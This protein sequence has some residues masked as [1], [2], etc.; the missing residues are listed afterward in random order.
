[1]NALFSFKCIVKKSFFNRGKFNSQFG[2]ISKNFLQNNSV[3]N[4]NNAKHFC[5]SGEKIQSQNTNTEGI[6][7]AK[8]F[9]KYSRKPKK[10]QKIWNKNASHKN[11]DIQRQIQY[12]KNPVNFDEQ[13]NIDYRRF[14][15]RNNINPAFTRIHDKWQKK[16]V[17]TRRLKAN[18]KVNLQKYVNLLYKYYLGKT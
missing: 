17:R 5:S 1:M 11:L 14:L 18:N 3:M 16:L 13:D 10:E 6:N 2:A 8:P 7:E 9:K 4:Y 12:S 15:L